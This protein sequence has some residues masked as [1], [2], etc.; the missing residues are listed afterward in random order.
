MGWWLCNCQS[1]C[2]YFSIWSLKYSAI[3][4]IIAHSLCRTWIHA[5]LE[6]PLWWEI[7]C[8]LWVYVR[9]CLRI[10]QYWKEIFTHCSH[11]DIFDNDLSFKIKNLVRREAWKSSSPAL[12]RFL[13]SIHFS[14]HTHVHSFIELSVLLRLSIKYAC[15]DLN[16]G[17]IYIP[18]DFFLTI[19]EYLLQKILFWGSTSLKWTWGQKKHLIRSRF[20]KL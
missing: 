10:F 2:R 14:Y 13:D 11:S 8:I 18:I 7:Q 20:I 9:L 3:S 5:V 4:N 1:H 15:I 16:S 6:S 19:W 12:C 17:Y